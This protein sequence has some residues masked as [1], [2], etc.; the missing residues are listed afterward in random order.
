MG[1]KTVILGFDGL[2]YPYL[3]TLVNKGELPNFKHIIQNGSY[4]PLLSTIPPVTIPAWP[5][6]FTGLD[7]GNL[8]TTRMTHI[9]RDYEMRVNR[10]NLWSE[11][12]I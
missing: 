7:I 12:F 11:S 6:M 4:G 3:T 9:T 10:A 5:S 8:G 1:R 2:C